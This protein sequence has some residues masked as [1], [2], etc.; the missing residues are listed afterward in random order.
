MDVSLIAELFSFS[1]PGLNPVNKKT[2]DALKQLRN[3]RNTTD[4]SDENEEDEELY[5]SSFLE[6]QNLRQFVAIV[7]K[8]EKTISDAKRLQYRQKYTSLIDTLKDKL[9]EER[10]ELI[11]RKK[12]IEKDVKTILESDD[13]KKEWNKFYDYYMMQH[14][15]GRED[16]CFEDNIKKYNAF[17]VLASDSG[18]VD[19]HI[20]AA[21]YYI[22]I[23]NYSEA[24][25]RL[26][27]SYDSTN[28]FEEREVED[29][30][31]TINIIMTLKKET[32]SD[33]MIEIM[34]GFKTKGF[35]IE[36]NSNGLYALAK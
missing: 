28:N 5:S 11:Q 18:I 36:K 14:V 4:H 24:E 6:L 8:Y 19:A 16:P 34:E 20:L 30:I 32:L 27:M 13:P 25:R 1:F 23:K 12:Q 7:D 15:R 33:E 22:S 9:D 29:I 31:S 26:R 3:D 2:K 10:I 21:D 35:N 17:V